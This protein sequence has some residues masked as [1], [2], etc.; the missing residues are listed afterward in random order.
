MP[1][2]EINSLD[3]LMDG[4]LK[5]RFSDAMQMV[6]TNIADPNTPPEAVRAITMQFKFKPNKSRDV[7]AVGVAV[8]TKLAPPDMLVNTVLIDRDDDGN[9][10][11]REITSQVPGQIDFDGKVHEQRIMVL[12][13]GEAK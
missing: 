6:M 13:K 7:A 5:E 9:I 12:G 3:A 11:A 10:I 1:S 4:A 2:R 8:N